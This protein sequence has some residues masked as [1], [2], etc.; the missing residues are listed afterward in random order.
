M[1]AYQKKLL[2]IA[3]FARCGSTILGN[4]LGE[5]EGFFN[6]GELMYIWDQVLSKDGTCGCGLHVTKCKVW[7]AIL[8]HG[9]AQ[10]DK[11]DF[12]ELIQIRNRIWGAKFVFKNFRVSDQNLISKSKIETYL[13]A[14][15]QFYSSI[16]TDIS[17]N[18]IIDTS[19]N[20]AYLYLLS[21]IKWIDLYVVHII[22]DPRATAYSWIAKKKGFY[23]VSN[24]RSSLRWAA[25]NFAVDLHKKRFY[26]KIIQIRYEDFISNP[27]EQLRNILKLVNE[28][29]RSLEF[30]RQEG[31]N[32]HKNHCVFG[33]PD[34]FKRGTVK[35]K[36]DK[37]WNKMRTKD[38]FL[39][40]FLTWPFMIR[41]GYPIFS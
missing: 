8:Q 12:N 1:A 15:E 17:E 40:T 24:T 23:K 22:R 13:A 39:T 33:N 2:Y 41:Y 10:Q 29:D 31:I 37:R 19:K 7:S 38:K 20:P 27:K 36:L 30:I 4:V 9:F 32:F 16:F 6:A 5:I 11:I 21:M 34:L 35:L 25:R 26:P 28:E 14:L 3:G 18:V